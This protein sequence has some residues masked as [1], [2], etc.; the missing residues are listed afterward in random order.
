[1]D[2]RLLAI[3]VAVTIK[4]VFLATRPSEEELIQDYMD[5]PGQAS[6]LFSKG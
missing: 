4:L 2:Y 5:N 6:E 3:L 1:M